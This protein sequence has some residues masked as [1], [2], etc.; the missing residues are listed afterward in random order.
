M[1]GIDTAGQAVA[2]AL[3]NARVGSS[4]EEEEEE[5]MIPITLLCGFLG[6]GK[7]TLLKHILENR[8][9]LKVGVIVNDVADVNIDAKLVRNQEKG[10]GGAGDIVSTSDVIELSNGCIC[11]R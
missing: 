9:G 7:T 10:A 1:A 8:V 2:T 6:A 5:D 11:C 3:G 4:D